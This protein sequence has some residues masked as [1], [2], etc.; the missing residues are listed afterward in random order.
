[1]KLEIICD[2]REPRPFRA[3]WL[4]NRLGSPKTIDTVYFFFRKI[5][6]KQDGGLDDMTENSELYW[7]DNGA[8]FEISNVDSQ[9]HLLHQVTESL[10]FRNEIWQT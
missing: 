7:A 1:M 6:P 10:T 5:F 9:L 8:V 4:L 2:F 3:F